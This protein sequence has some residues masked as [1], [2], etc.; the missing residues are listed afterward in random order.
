MNAISEY[1]VFAKY[2]DELMYDVDYPAIA[3]YLEEIIK[4]YSDVKVESGAKPLILDLGCGTGEICIE[5]AQKGYEMIGID[6]SV[7]MLNYALN[8]SLNKELDVLFINQDMTDFE[9]YGTVSAVFCL[10]DGVNHV[11]DVN[12]L[13]RMFELIVNYLEPGGLFIF[14]IN[15]P[16][17]L[18]RILRDKI[19]YDVNDELSYIWQSRSSDDE[20]VIQFDLT[21]FINSKIEDN[22]FNKPTSANED[23]YVKRD[24]YIKERI[25]D[26]DF[27]SGL[28][29]DAGFSCIKVYGNKTF[30]NPSDQ[31]DRIFFVA[32]N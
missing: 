13:K 11:T 3:Q 32:K 25:Y 24:I 21:F 4:R 7:D 17:K 29:D 15:S 18:N 14:D 6:Q 16:H 12:K 20:D 5:F 27:L 8:K 23:F 31:E 26:V 2:Y 9:L 28:L 22:A 19:Y 30:E 1:D 10:L